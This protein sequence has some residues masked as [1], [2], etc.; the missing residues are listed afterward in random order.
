[1]FTSQFA[2][3]TVERA[4]KSAAQAVILVLGA[5]QVDALTVDWGTAG[6]FAAGAFVLSAL[7]SIVSAG[8]GPE[9]SPSVV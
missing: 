2:I 9:D 7:T 1:M 3:E 5:G 4:V 6:G 8:V